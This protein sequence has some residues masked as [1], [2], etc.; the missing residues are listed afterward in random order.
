MSASHA[1]TKTNQTATDQRVG[2]ADGGSAFVN[3][4][5]GGIHVTSADPTVSRAALAAADD[6]G[7]AGLLTADDLAK[8]GLKTAVDISHE[9]GNLVSRQSSAA[10]QAEDSRS[11]LFENALAAQQAQLLAIEELGKNVSSGGQSDFNKTLLYLGVAAAA[12]IA[13][14]FIFRK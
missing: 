5:G 10:A 6:L 11:T 7:R 9:F 12:A 13:S 2:A 8:Y 14:I 1:E 3:Y 4:G